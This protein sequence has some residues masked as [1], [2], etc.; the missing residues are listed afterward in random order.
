MPFL[1]RPFILSCFIHTIL[2]LLCSLIF[3]LKKDLVIK[4]TI[5]DFINSSGLEKG[6][7]EVINKFKS[8]KKTKLRDLPIF[9]QENKIEDETIRGGSYKVED[10]SNSTQTLSSR[11]VDS[12]MENEGE[13][14]GKRMFESGINGGYTGGVEL[15]G[16]SFLTRARIIYPP[17]AKKYAREGIVKLHLLINEKG[18]LV[19]VEIVE[20]PGYAMGRA[21]VDMVKNS[22]FLPAIV[23]GEPRGCD[24][25]LTIRFV[26]KKGE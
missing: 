13:L 10:L 11:G 22:K 5:I 24:A 8:T 26:L 16:C 2:F 12:N 7:Y 3:T 14:S 21:A 20:D 6:G 17:L 25:T 18:D 1:D 4:S 15:N 23:N 19:S 9:N